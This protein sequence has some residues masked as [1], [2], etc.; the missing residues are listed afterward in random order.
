[1][2]PDQQFLEFVFEHGKQYIP[3]ILPKDISRGEIRLCYDNCAARVLHSKKYKYVEGIVRDPNIDG[4]A[5]RWILH[6]WITDGVHA[7]DPTWKCLNNKTGEEAP[8]PTIYIGLEMPIRAVGEFMIETEYGGVCAN[9]W[10][11][12][13]LAQKCF[14]KLPA[15]K[16]S[17]QFLVELIK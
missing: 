1:M 2:D 8:M 7:F 9:A 6:A 16:I 4:V 17:T 12:P 15:N 10:R 3:A 14:S 11:S 13:S 5:H